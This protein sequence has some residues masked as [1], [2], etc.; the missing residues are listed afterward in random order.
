MKTFHCT[1]CQ[2]LIF[3]ENVRCLN[4][5]HPLAF[6]PDLGVMAALSESPDGLWRSEIRTAPDQAAQAPPAQD[7][8][9]QAPAYRLC[10]NYDQVSVC[11]W[12]VPADD[13]NR[14]AARAG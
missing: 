1:H 8:P 6:L 3:F 4:C 14:S 2:N 5:G 11:N 7:P 9:A 13:P 10:A 12:V